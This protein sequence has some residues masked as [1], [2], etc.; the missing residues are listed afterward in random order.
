MTP[1]S[2]FPAAARSN[3]ARS[4]FFGTMYGSCAAKKAAASGR[5]VAEVEVG[6]FAR[7]LREPV[8]FGVTCRF[9]ILILS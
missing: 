5:D 2:H 1:V 4:A 7:R 9:A 8:S 6:G 3:L